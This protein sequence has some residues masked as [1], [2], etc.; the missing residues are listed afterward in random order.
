[1]Y[2]TRPETM[3]AFILNTIV[4]NCLGHKIQAENYIR[5]SGLNYAIVRPGGL[6]G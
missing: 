3:V 4:G 2:V 5:G 1:M 6:G